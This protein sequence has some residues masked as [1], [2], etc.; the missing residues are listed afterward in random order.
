MHE[1]N[2]NTRVIVEYVTIE[3]AGVSSNTSQENR[4]EYH[5]GKHYEREYMDWKLSLKE[6]PM[7]QVHRSNYGLKEKLNNRG[8]A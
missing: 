8:V 7:I 2:K 4:I 6:I 5:T 1:R 3:D